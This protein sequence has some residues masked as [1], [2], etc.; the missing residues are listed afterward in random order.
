MIDVS[1][2]SLQSS[3][4]TKLGH[5]LIP[6]VYF[7]DLVVLQICHYDIIKFAFNEPKTLHGNLFICPHAPLLAEAQRMRHLS[8]VAR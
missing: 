4:V 1:L 3:F 6:V 8:S 5:F 2:I 7:H